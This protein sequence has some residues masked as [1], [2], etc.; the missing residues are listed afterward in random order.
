MLVQED[1]VVA[2]LAQEELVLQVMDLQ[3]QQTQVVVV[4]QVDGL[5]EQFQ[6]VQAVAV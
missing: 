1:M 2:E 3:V 4:E 5:L 6:V